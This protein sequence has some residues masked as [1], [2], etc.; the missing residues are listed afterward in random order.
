MSAERLGAIHHTKATVLR[1]MAQNSTSRIEQEKYRREAKELLGKLMATARDSYAV[2][3]MAQILFDEIEEIL[4]ELEQNPDE[5][6]GRVLTNLIAHAE[7]VV[8]RGLQR[9]TDDEYIRTAQARLAD[10]LNDRPTAVAALEAAAR[11]TPRS[12]FVATRLAKYYEGPEQTG[13]RQAD[14]R[15]LS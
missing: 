8:S 12:D 7:D 14:P 3:G 1:R 13:R 6:Q 10:I 11:A 9:F 4:K 15:D 2:S 5:L